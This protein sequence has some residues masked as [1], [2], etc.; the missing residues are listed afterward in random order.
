MIQTA[1][2]LNPIA[3]IV[4]VSEGCNAAILSS[5]RVAAEEAAAHRSVS[6]VHHF[7]DQHYNRSSFILAG[8]RSGVAAA[9]LQVSATALDLIDLRAHESTH[10][11]VGVVDHISLAPLVENMEDARMAALALSE[12]LANELNLPVFLYGAAHPEGRSLA[13][14][15]RSCGLG[16]FK[17]KS[18][19]GLADEMEAASQT[20]LSDAGP[21]VTNPQ[22]GVV[23]CGAVPMVLNYNVRLKTKCQTAA[24]RIARKVRTKNGGLPFVEALALQHQGGHYEVAC[25]LLEPSRTTPL[26]VLD[27]I[28]LAARE[29]GIDIEEEYTIGLR[30]S[31]I[32]ERLETPVH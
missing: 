7:Q 21:S 8:G 3:C 4:Y 9:A 24:A 30:P 26:Q 10:P 31:Q 5:L 15:R 1:S 17:K 12:N 18:S 6:L 19:T 2:I 25:N 11:R 29:V 14:T 28:T 16:Y 23:C 22:H 13:E 32:L 20:V 27:M